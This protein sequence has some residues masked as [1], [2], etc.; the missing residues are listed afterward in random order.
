M[1]YEN[2]KRLLD[3]LLSSLGLIIASP[4]FLLTA[5][6]I[7][8]TSPGPIFAD[9]PMRVGKNGSLFKM[10]KFRSMVPNAQ[11]LLQKNPKL[12]AE[13]KKNSYKIHNDP[14]VTQVGKFIRRYSI[15]ELPQLLNI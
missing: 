15:D 6:A 5:L 9:T 10:Y 3:F 8:I 13:Y 4:I 12:F 2:L 14:R 1:V 11:E 7:K